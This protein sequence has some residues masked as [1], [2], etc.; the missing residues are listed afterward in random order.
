MY[1]ILMYCVL[2]IRF[3][4]ILDGIGGYE[5]ERG[6]HTR[7]PDPGHISDREL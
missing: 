6:C 7:T 1:C 5:Q 3:S 2:Y 4:I